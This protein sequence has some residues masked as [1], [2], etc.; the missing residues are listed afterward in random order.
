MGP[1]EVAMSSA[2]T[3]HDVPDADFADAVLH[4]RNVIAAQLRRLFPSLDV[5][6]IDRY[7]PLSAEVDAD[8][9]DLTALIRAV[10]DATGI[11]LSARLVDERTSLEDL[12]RAL[13]TE[14]RRQRRP[15]RPSDGAPTVTP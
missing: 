1:K 3:S 2:T 4:A 7:Q 13:A 9:D 11:A 5:G 10:R 6:D 12:A 14:Q 15:A 8:N